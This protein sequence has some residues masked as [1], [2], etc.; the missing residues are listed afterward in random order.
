MN[1]MHVIF[2]KGNSR[3]NEKYITQRNISILTTAMHGH[4]QNFRV[5]EGEQDLLWEYKYII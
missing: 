5:A 4:F 3:Y 2:K 1:I